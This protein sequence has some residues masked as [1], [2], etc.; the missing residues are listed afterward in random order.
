MATPKNFVQEYLPGYAR[1]AKGHP[2]NWVKYILTHRCADP[3]FVLLETFLPAFVAMMYNLTLPD[4]K[5]ILRDFAEKYERGGFGRSGSGVI[6]SHI[7]R[8]KT[9]AK[10]G[11]EPYGRFNGLRLTLFLTQPQETIGWWISVYSESGLFWKRWQTL[12][13]QQRYCTD[14]RPGPFQ[15]TDPA[16][17]YAFNPTEGAVLLDFLEQNRDGWANNNVF[18]SLPPGEYIAIFVCQIDPNFSN[19]AQQDCYLWLQPSDF[20]LFGQ[21]IKGQVFT[22]KPGA[23]GGGAITLTFRILS[24]SGGIAWGAGGN[25]AVGAA[26][27]TGHVIVSGTGH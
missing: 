2:M 21:K 18:V 14:D 7:S 15:R 8:G 26:V 13:E 24:F 19:L 25:N 4:W 17:A 3:Y 11:P 1:Q 20:G 22:C 9:V 16:A 10:R 5:D 12:L 23:G 27:G 6:K